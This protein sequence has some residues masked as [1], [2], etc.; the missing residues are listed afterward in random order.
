MQ[1]QTFTERYKLVD[2]FDTTYW[3]GLDMK[4]YVGRD[5]PILIDEMIQFNYQI[6][7][8]VIPYYG[9]HSGVAQRLHHGNRIVQG[10]LTI[11]YKRDSYPFALLEYIRGHGPPEILGDLD[12][13][14]NEPANFEGAVVDAVPTGADLDD[15]SR[16]INQDPASGTV[17]LETL[18]DQ[19]ILA[20]A[21]AHFEVY[22]NTQAAED[23][24]PDQVYNTVRGV[25]RNDVGMFQTSA[26][27]FEMSILVGTE[28][29]AS[30]TLR[31]NFDSSYLPDDSPPTGPIG[32]LPGTGMRFIGTSIMGISRTMDDSGRNFVETLTFMARTV[33][34]VSA[35]ELT[36]FSD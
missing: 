14:V 9:Y 12:K 5:R 7:E 2:A 20:T 17:S 3:S 27:G 19:E 13:D 8:Q 36:S 34:P 33:I 22:K 26:R 28:V 6:L 18:T 25:V 1:P 16:L 11:N 32:I 15:T 23:E 35:E 24:R 31:Y 30:Q 10:E 29:R 21:F 4:L